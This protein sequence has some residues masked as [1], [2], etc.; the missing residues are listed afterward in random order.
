MVT[1]DLAFRSFGL[2]AFHK[3]FTRGRR[4]ARTVRTGTRPHAAWIVAPK[5]HLAP[6][7][8][9]YTFQ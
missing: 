2:N 8:V 6:R 9:R 5:C 1:A 7:Y 3:Q 4:G